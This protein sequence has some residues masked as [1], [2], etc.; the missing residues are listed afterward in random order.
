VLTGNQYHV[1][2][3]GVPGGYGTFSGTPINL[4][5][6]NFF[7]DSTTAAGDLNTVISV[8]N[9]ATYN[10]ALTDQQLSGHYQ[11]GIGHSGEMDTTRALRLLNYYWSSTVISGVA[12][13]NMSNQVG[14]ISTQAAT[15]PSL[16]Q[17]LQD[18]TTTGDGFLWVDSYGVVHVD[19]RETR[20]TAP[21]SAA[22]QFTFSDNPTDIAAGAIVYEDLQYDYDPT[23]VYSQAQFTVD[24]TN[25]VVTVTNQT[26]ATNYG[27]RILSQTVYVPDDWEALQAANFAVQRYAAPAGAAGSATAYRINTLRI[28]PATNPALWQA[29]LSL[30]IDDRITVTKKTAAGTVITGDYYIEQ[31]QHNVDIGSSQWTVNYQ[32]SPVWNPNPFIIGQSILGGGA[33]WVY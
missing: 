27:Q 8:A 19:S 9:M 22:S 14:T 11:R 13:T 33:T 31:V 32:L 20:Y 16:L 12:Q 1:Y 7:I 23:Y 25:D 15:P 3:D 4:S 10:Y 26:S 17:D 29:A 18:I 24:G 21:R 2:V 30:D 6:N 28:N 5:I